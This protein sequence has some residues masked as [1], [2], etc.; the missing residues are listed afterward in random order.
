MA[1]SI[2]TE[3]KHL[4]TVL[5]RA[6]AHEGASFVEIYQNCPVYNDGIFEVIKEKKTAGETRLILEHGQPMIFGTE[7]DKGIKLNA[8][9]LALEVVTLGEDGVTEEDLS[10]TMRPTA[11]A[12]LTHCVRLSSRTCWRDCATPKP[13]TRTRS[14]NRSNGP[15]K[16]GLQ[17]SRTH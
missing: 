5:K 13:R 4:T 11:L 16:R 7:R 1:R 9:T 10:F 3:A 17:I 2:D 8:A 15:E 14:M 12:Q 6:H